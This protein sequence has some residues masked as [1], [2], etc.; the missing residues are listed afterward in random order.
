MNDDL[1]KIFVD[2]YKQAREHLA[3]L[4]QEVAKANARISQLKYMLS[5]MNLEFDTDTII[6]ERR[7]K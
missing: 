2:M 6:I 4:N 7:N 3:S 5:L 1:E